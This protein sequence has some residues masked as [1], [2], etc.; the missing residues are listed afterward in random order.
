VHDVVLSLLDPFGDFDF[1]I[2]GQERNG[3]HLTQIQAHRV[4][5]FAQDI[6]S[7]IEGP[8]ILHVISGQA[9]LGCA[10][11]IFRG[12]FRIDEIDIQITECHQG[13]NVLG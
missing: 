13:V 2:A 12:A 10:G 4:V 9:V 1:P 7:Q 3:P 8:A 11:S 5:G 6:G